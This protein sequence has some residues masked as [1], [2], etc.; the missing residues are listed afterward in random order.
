MNGS[1]YCYYFK[2]FLCSVFEPLQV[3]ILNLGDTSHS[4]YRC[5]SLSA[6]ATSSLF[7]EVI[8]SYRYFPLKYSYFIFYI[9]KISMNFEIIIMIRTLIFC[10]I[11]FFSILG[12]FSFLKIKICLFARIQSPVYYFFKSK[13][14]SV[15]SKISLIHEKS[16]LLLCYC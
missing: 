10:N 15:Y 7:Y 11:F 13:K 1:Y 3:W 4:E 2:L 5:N 6:Q 16:F 12:H 8:D 9:L 14:Y